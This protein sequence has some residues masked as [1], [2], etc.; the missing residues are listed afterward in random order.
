MNLMQMLSKKDSVVSELTKGIEFYLKRT[1]WNGY[2]ERLSL[3]L[4]QKW[5]LRLIA[6]KNSNSS[7]QNNDCGGIRTCLSAQLSL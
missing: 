4:I 7:R 6:E 2:L 3:D 5:R 1:K